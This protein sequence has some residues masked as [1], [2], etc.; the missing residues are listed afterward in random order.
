MAFE[1]R[2]AGGNTYV[3]HSRRD[4]ATGKV[5]KVYLGRGPRADA[6]AAELEARRKQGAAARLAV[7][8]AGVELHPVG[9]LMAALD[10]GAV[11]LM[12]AALL[13]ANWHRHNYGPW[14]RRRTGDD[15]GRHRTDTAAGPAG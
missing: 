3:Y 4:P 5:R 11:L 7:E 6:A 13:A 15:H 1:T 9:V 10:E 8:R 12:E 2:K 14:R